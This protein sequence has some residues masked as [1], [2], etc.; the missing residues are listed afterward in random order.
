MR[1]HLLPSALVAISVAAQ[2]SASGASAGFQPAWW[3]PGPHA[4][5]ICGSLCRRS[6]RVPL[7]RS[8]WELP[9]GDFLD[10]DELAGVLDAPLL[11]VLHGLEGS[12]RTVHVLELLRQAHQ[13][14]WAGLAINFRSCSGE[15]NRLPRSYHGGD[16]ADL[17]W[18]INQ[19]RLREPSRRLV[20]VGFSLGGNV[21][22][23]YL[24]EQGHALPE[25]IVA[26]AAVSAPFDLAASVQALSQGFSRVYMRRL[27]NSLKSKMVLRLETFPDLVDRN[28]L[29]AVKTLGEFDDLVTGPIHGFP[30]AAA[31]W[32]S[33]S[34][35]QFLSRISCP[36][37]LV[38]AQDD[39]F[40]P[41]ASLPRPDA[42]NNPALTMDFP[43][44]GGHLGFVTGRWPLRA[45]S[46]AESRVMRFLR[47]HAG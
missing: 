9:D 19:V 45:E 2:A 26:A 10:I 43:A 24:G 31:Y 32:A 20:C 37:L 18:V 4:Q 6:P 12:S 1:R 30:N 34:S 13:L 27:V 38:N 25:Q 8:R 47:D 40:L 16:T 21:L 44:S 39:P 17:S 36:T 28:A 3:C 11:I 14:G 5:T 46:W 29:L 42:V 41:A 7:T 22:L 15:L 35:G 23:K 33:S